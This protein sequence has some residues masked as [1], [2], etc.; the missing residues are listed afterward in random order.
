M[1]KAASS[2]EVIGEWLKHP[3][4]AQATRWQLYKKKKQPRLSKRSCISKKRLIW[5]V[6]AL[7]PNKR[8]GTKT[9]WPIPRP[10]R[11][12]SFSLIKVLSQRVFLGEVFNEEVLQGSKLDLG[13]ARVNLEG[14][15]F[16]RV[17]RL[18]KWSDECAKIGS[19]P[20]GT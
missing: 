5:C 10:W 2:V 11:L 19:S 8:L 18:Q 15:C 13:S 3:H 16:G 1:S 6:R 17:F 14:E 7:Q 4:V 9:H 20:G 12:Y